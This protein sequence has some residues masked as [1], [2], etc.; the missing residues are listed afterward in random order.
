MAF[1]ASHGVTQGLGPV[2]EPLRAYL[3]IELGFLIGRFGIFVKVLKGWLK[4]VWG[5]LWRLWMF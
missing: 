2:L 1:T 4:V 5:V 3:S